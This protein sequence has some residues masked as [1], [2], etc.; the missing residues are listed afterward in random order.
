MY[1]LVP[2]SVG[3]MTFQ[4]GQPNGGKESKLI[5]S[6]LTWDARPGNQDPDW[7]MNS[8]WMQASWNSFI[9]PG[10]QVSYDTK[11]SF[12][13]I[14]LILRVLPGPQSRRSVRLRGSHVNL[15]LQ[16]SSSQWFIM[17]CITQL[18]R[19]HAFMLK[20]YIA[21]TINTRNISYS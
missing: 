10:Q 6:S 1:R 17:N 9:H 4:P 8:S 11:L 20:H 16:C 18:S 21:L 15:V 14:E 5:I 7:I 19:K 12:N 3:W 2:L 13:Y